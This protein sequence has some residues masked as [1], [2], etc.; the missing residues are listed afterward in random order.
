MKLD[1]WG[2]KFTDRIFPLVGKD[3]FRITIGS[4]KQ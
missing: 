4:V 2:D 1:V 3:N